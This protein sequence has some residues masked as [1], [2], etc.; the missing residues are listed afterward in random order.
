LAELP[1]DPHDPGDDET[2]VPGLATWPR[3]YGFV[4]GAFVL[5]VVLLTILM[6]TFT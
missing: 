3:V 6:R 4:V 5:W 1:L 2:D